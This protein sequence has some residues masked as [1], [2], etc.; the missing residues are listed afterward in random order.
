MKSIRLRLLLWV[1]SFIITIIAIFFVVAVLFFVI[2]IAKSIV[3]YTNSSPQ[4]A[5]AYGTIFLAIATILLVLITYYNSE[6]EKNNIFIKK[7]LEDF[8][9][10]LIYYFTFKEVFKEDY[11]QINKI[12]LKK[13]YLAKEDSENKIP[14][15]FAKPDDVEVPPNN[16]ASINVPLDGWFF[17]NKQVLEKWVTIFNILKKDR[18]ELANRYR[19]LNGAKLT[20]NTLEIP[21]HNFHINKMRNQI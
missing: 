2:T 6:K 18:I 20:E 17:S 21:K 5:I 15:S 8:Y 16:V 12:L 9:D 1:Q 19:K 3:N 4:L 7:Q 10:P 13:S 14:F 11:Y